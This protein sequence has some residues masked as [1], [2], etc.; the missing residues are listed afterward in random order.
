[1]VSILV[2]VDELSGLGVKDI[3]DLL[4]IKSQSLL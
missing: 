4:I 1:M 3:D 2:V